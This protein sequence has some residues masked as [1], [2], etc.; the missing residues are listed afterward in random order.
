MLFNR[1]PAYFFLTNVVIVP[2]ASLIIITGCIIP[3]LY[4]LALL[5]GLMGT[6]L[7]YLTGFT[8]F[9]TEKAASLPGSSIGGIG[10]TAFEC[11]ILTCI[12]TVL[13]YTLINNKLRFVKHLLILVIIIAIA[14]TI[15]DIYVRRSNELIV[16][17]S[18]G[19]T[20]V[21]IRTG[22]ILNLYS[23]GE[24]IPPEVL[25]HS[26]TLGLRIEKKDPSNGTSCIEAAG[27]KILIT[28]SAGRSRLS[29]L[30]PDI[31]ILSGSKPFI[32]DPGG[33]RFPRMVITSSEVA[34]RFRIPGDLYSSP[35][36]LAFEVR[37]A[38]AFR[39]SL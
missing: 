11:I 22:K 32:E 13:C 38:G 37:K 21:G 25:R 5:S 7:N 36:R 1:F 31:V 4:P 6:F 2:L 33:L 16:Y 39:M 35:D 30:T 19:A 27:K 24:D 28:T 8:E 10:M 26:S 23:T 34:Y 20:V 17:N 9:L 18:P 14:G 15:R 3:L 12:I 29:S